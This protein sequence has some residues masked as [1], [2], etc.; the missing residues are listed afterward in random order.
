[1]EWGSTTW[2]TVDPFRGIGHKDHP[3]GSVMVCAYDPRP[4]SHGQFHCNDMST[5]DNPA[6]V[7]SRR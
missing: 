3:R 1:M 5:P 2:F 6:G 4:F 7:W